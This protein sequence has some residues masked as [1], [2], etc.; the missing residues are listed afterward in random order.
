VIQEL[1]KAAEENKRILQPLL[2]QYQAKG[3]AAH[4]VPF[5]VIN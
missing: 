2:S 1:K 4:I 3:E 5:W